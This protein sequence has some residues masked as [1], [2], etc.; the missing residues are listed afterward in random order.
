MYDLENITADWINEYKMQGWRDLDVLAGSHDAYVLGITSFCALGIRR[1][2]LMLETVML[3]ACQMLTK[4]ANTVRVL[5]QPGKGED[6][7][8]VQLPIDPSLQL[9]FI[10][11]V[12][13]NKPSTGTC[14]KLVTIF[15][16]DFWMTGFS[17]DLKSH[18]IFVP[19]WQCKTTPKSDQAF[20][21]QEL[22]HLKL[23]LSVP[24]GHRR[25]QPNMISEDL[26]F[27]FQSCIPCRLL[28]SD[29][30]MTSSMS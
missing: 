4:G 23:R 19:A 16:I 29:Q 3:D 5:P 10:G 27:E 20:F 8:S 21:Q 24:E 26:R 7:I 6:A 1:L 9:P 14:Y 15:G 28:F 18:S 11:S 22:A 30:S 17:G 12:K 13:A 25:S 2:E